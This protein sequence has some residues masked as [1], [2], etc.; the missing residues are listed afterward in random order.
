MKTMHMETAKVANAVT[1]AVLEIMKPGSGNGPGETRRRGMIPRA[2]AL[3]GLV[4]ACVGRGDDPDRI[5]TAQQAISGEDGLAEAF[6]VFTQNFVV[7]GQDQRFTIGFGFHPG[8]VT[9]R[10]AVAGAAASGSATLV[11]AEGRVEATLHNVPDDQR[12]D[13]WFVKNVAGNGRTVRP[14]SGDQLLRIGSFQP[15]TTANT[16]TLSAVVG[17]AGVGFDLDEVVVTAAGRS[18]VS[19]VV[20]SGARTLLEKRFFR[21]R[22][23]GGLDPVTGTTTNAVESNDQLIARGAQLFFSETFGGNGR[24]C[25]TCHPAENNLTIDPAFIRTLPPTDP[26]FVAETNPALAQL[27]NSTL[28]REDALILENIDGFEDPTH[29]F[30]LRGV[31]HT[32]AMSTSTGRG[33]T[34]CSRPTALR[35]TFAPAGAVTAR[36][37]A[38]ASTSSRSARSSST[39]PRASIAGWGSTSACRPRTSSTRSRRSSCSAVVS[40]TR[41]PGRS[42]SARRAPRTARTCSSVRVWPATAT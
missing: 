32:L 16:H 35:P 14:D 23:G 18:P 39:S 15:S 10:V 22:A 42:R 3:A 6:Q 24:T 5:G 13:L 37:G 26:L 11:F 2:L 7:D 21:E 41:T 34:F 25:G 31:P 9:Q 8:L 38:A 1:A 27:E 17:D 40:I 4:G 30:V 20:A 36:P 29:K 19:S 28:L 33:D 12:F